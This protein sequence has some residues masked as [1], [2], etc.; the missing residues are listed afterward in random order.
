MFTQVNQYGTVVQNHHGNLYVM[1]LHD[2][3]LVQQRQ[4]V[5]SQL[6]EV[7]GQPS[8]I[9]VVTQRSNHQGGVF[10]LRK[11]PFVPDQHVVHAVGDGETVFEVVVRVVPVHLPHGQNE[12]HQHL[13]VQKLLPDN[14]SK[15][16]NAVLGHVLKQI[17]RNVPEKP[18]EIRRKID[19]H[20]FLQE[21]SVVD[22][23]PHVSHQHVDVTHVEV[24]VFGHADSKL[25][26]M[27]RQGAIH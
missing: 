21:L 24:L 13:H 18:V 4:I 3:L 9:Y 26:E 10:D 7:I 25:I 15:H 11:Y 8:V 20:V 5:S 1:I 12:P 27:Q 16:K 2:R 14:F 17:L 23:G 19:V 22:A 6:Q